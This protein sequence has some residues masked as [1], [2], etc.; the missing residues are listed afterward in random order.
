MENQPLEQVFHEAAERYH[1]QVQALRKPGTDECKW[2]QEQAV[3]ALLRSRDRIQLPGAPVKKR[4]EISRA[5]ARH[6][7]SKAIV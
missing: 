4:V 5:K 6:K 2:T 1:E 3:L 7:V